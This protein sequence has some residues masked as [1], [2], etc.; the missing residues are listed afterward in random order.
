MSIQG[1]RCCLSV[2]HKTDIVKYTDT[3]ITAS[4][5]LLHPIM[6]LSQLASELRTLMLLTKA[7]LFFL[8]WQWRSWAT[9]SLV[10][11][12]C[13]MWE[14]T[15]VCSEARGNRF[16]GENSELEVC[17]KHLFFLLSFQLWAA[18]DLLLYCC[19]TCKYEE[20]RSLVVSYCLFF[21]CNP[22][23]SAITALL[24]LGATSCCKT[25]LTV[26]L[27][28]SYWPETNVKCVLSSLRYSN[29]MH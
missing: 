5:M 14:Q 24:Q 12:F 19:H 7:D 11:R 23:G 25:S 29:I 15:G 8:P 26:V 3:V 2:C 27:V 20:S 17:A 6:S 13:S 4:F 28:I 10:L 16:K 22:Y 9:E 1:D 21:V 18:S